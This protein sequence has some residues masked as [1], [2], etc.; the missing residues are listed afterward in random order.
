MTSFSRWTVSNSLVYTLTVVR[1]SHRISNTQKHA[2]LKFYPC[3]RSRLNVALVQTVIEAYAL[4][5]FIPV[6]IRL[7]INCVQLC[8]SVPP[9]NPRYN[10]KSR[11]TP[12][13]QRILHVNSSQ[14]PCSA[15]NDIL[16]EMSRK[17]LQS[18]VAVDWKRIAWRPV[19]FKPLLHLT[20]TSHG[21]RSSWKR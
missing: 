11:S 15:C 5:R 19:C 7:R 14:S 8:E 21:S 17:W 12:C 9:Q 20:S 10:P 1:P 6:K 18:S 2:A 16:H 13:V 4:S 3:S